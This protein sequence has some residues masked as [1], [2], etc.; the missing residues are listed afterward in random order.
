MGGLLPICRPLVGNNKDN[1]KKNNNKNKNSDNEAA[2][3]KRI[4]RT[5]KKTLQRGR[6]LT[7]TA[8]RGLQQKQ[9]MRMSK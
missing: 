1:K 5:Q 3:T 9:E 2:L 4:S 7:K 8:K 6:L